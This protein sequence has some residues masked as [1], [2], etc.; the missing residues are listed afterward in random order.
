MKTNLNLLFTI[1]LTLGFVTVANSQSNNAL[2]IVRGK[3]DTV[4]TSLHYIVGVAAPGS[5]VYVNDQPVKQYTTGS[6]GTELTLKEG[7]NPI[8]VKVK[9]GAGE[10]VENFSVYFKKPIIKPLAERV[11]FFP[12]R[13]VKTKA[14]AYLNYGAG[15][16]RLGGAKINFLAEGIKMEVIDSV[17]NLYQVKLSDNRYAFIPKSF[18]EFTTFG[19]EPTKSLS[20]S[21]S[22][23]NTGKSDRI[24]ISLD[25]RQPY[26]IYRELDPN[27]LVVEIHGTKC[28]SN[29]ITQYLNLK[30]IEY[31]H[32]RQSES[33]VLSVIIKL[34]DKYSWGYSVDYSGSALDINIKHTPATILQSSKQTFKGLVFGVD[35]GHGGSATGAVS[36]SGIQ[37][38]NL[39]LDMAYVLKDELEKRGAKVVLSRKEDVDVA[40][41]ERVTTFRNENID[42]M[43]SIHCNAGGTPL[44]PMG[45]STYYRHIEYRALA[46]T[47]LKRLTEMNVVNF[48]LVGNFNFSLNAPSD[49]PTVLV[50][51]MFMSSLP[52]EEKIADPAF[53]KEMM[54]KVVKGLED[55]IK[56]VKGEF[57][58]K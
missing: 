56:L 34:K 8:T 46:E 23:V 3:S 17:N 57:K 12:G 22:V 15:E 1:L 37:E 47:I 35:A 38:K 49:F 30:V 36:P 42:L 7:D 58:V 24:R 9:S 39:N 31:V 54:L 41:L 26:T 33:D 32:L 20:G 50:E 53:R 55:Y 40:M 19:T 27:I 45:T 28:N 10:T 52:D 16:D 25:N 29:W 13:V 21:W 11:T 44:K 5:E 4:T 6:F 2:K 43:V 51:T 48:G 18:T 14:G